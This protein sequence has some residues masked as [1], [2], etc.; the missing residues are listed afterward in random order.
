MDKSKCLMLMLWA[1]LMALCFTILGT[2]LSEPWSNIFL[3][4]TLLPTSICLY[5]C[6]KYV[7][8]NVKDGR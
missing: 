3:W 1:F 6:W 2:C 4:L 7:G 8:V 5:F